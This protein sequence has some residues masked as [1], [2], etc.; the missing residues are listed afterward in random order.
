MSEPTPIAER[1][2][3]LQ[4]RIAAAARRSGRSPDAVRLVGVSKR[5]DPERIA[6][7]VE[8]GLRD[9]GENYVQEL[10]DKRPAVE[11]QLEA[12]GG[13]TA[14]ALR[15][16]L[17]GPLQRNKVRPA[18][19]LVDRIA[20]VD[21]LSLAEEIEKRA[22]AAG[23]RIEVLLQVNVSEEPQKAGVLPDALPEL[24]S[25]CRPLEHLTVCGLMAI[26]AA[27]DD[28]E[29]SRPAFARLRHLRDSLRNGPGGDEL[30]E[31]SMGMSGD[32]E[33][34]IEEGATEV[35]VGTALFGP[36]EPREEA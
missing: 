12:R 21:R 6:A 23:R 20:S 22:A 25:A 10:R 30:V 24:L 17:I 18:L 13:R 8:A 32:F 29:R 11:A 16:H 31:L 33:V 34:A 27:S 28:P 7:A 1:L 35:R 3:A 26:P 9:L 4:E 2:T 19:E 5:V 14:G 36:R 15:W